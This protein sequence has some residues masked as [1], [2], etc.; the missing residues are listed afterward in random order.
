VSNEYAVARIL[1]G[2]HDGVHEPLLTGRAKGQS[3]LTASCDDL[4]L[5][6]GI[7]K[8]NTI[9]IEKGNAVAKPPVWDG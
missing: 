2:A 6:I 1:K 7:Q 8:G 5:V 3:H 4:G 9:G